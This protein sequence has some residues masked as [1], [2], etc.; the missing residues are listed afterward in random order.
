MTDTEGSRLSRGRGCRKKQDQTEGELRRRSSE[1]RGREHGVED[2][3]ILILIE[4]KE[5][6]GTLRLGRAELPHTSPSR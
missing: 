6:F 5:V 2:R 4:G 1:G 3:F